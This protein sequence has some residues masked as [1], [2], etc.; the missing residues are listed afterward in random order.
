MGMFDGIGSALTSLPVLSTAGAM[1]GSL[2]SYE[3]QRQANATNMDIANNQMAFQERMS[4]T[5]YQRAVSD[6]KA[7]GLNPALAYQQGGASSPAGASTTVQNEMA[8]AVNSGMQALQIGSQLMN[9]MVQRDKTKSET[10]LNDALSIKAAQE[11]VTSKSSAAKI[12]QEIDNLMTERSRIIA[13]TFRIRA[14]TVVESSKFDLN[15]AYQRLSEIDAELHAYGI[16]EARNAAWAADTWFGRKVMPFL[17]SAVKLGGTAAAAGTLRSRGRGG[18]TI[19]NNNN[20]AGYRPSYGL[21]A[22]LAR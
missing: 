7:A 17:S 3:G 6:I 16:P 12:E 19:N 18:I 8:P 11:T 14:G 5:A 13:D 15:R 1:A 22:D 20:R 4:S 10:N 21:N 9:D 2:F